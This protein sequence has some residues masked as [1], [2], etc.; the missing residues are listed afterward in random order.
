MSERAK[1]LR[2]AGGA[3][4]GAAQ[5]T[6]GARFPGEDDFALTVAVKDRRGAHVGGDRRAR[7]R[8][9]ASQTEIEGAQEQGLARTGLTRQ[10]IEAEPNSRRAS[11]ITPSPWA[12]SS[13]S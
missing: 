6:R 2:A 3:I 5:S 13:N 7:C 9:V 12:Y 10:H 1:C 8:T 4:D 11:W